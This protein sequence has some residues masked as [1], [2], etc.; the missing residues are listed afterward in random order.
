MCLCCEGQGHCLSAVCM[1]SCTG[2]GRGSGLLSAGSVCGSWVK[3]S[4]C[5]CWAR[6]Y[7]KH[8]SQRATR[9]RWDQPTAL[10]HAFHK[11]GMSWILNVEIC[12]CLQLHV[13]TSDKCC[14]NET[15]ICV[16]LINIFITAAS[17]CRK[18]G[19]SFFLS[20]CQTKLITEI[21]GKIMTKTEK[22]NPEN[23][24]GV[25]CELVNCEIWQH[26]VDSI[27]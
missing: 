1:Y 19:F 4:T 14:S 7:L 3:K 8:F 2:R 16:C 18:K 9:P 10:M 24:K 6:D 26:C 25:N 12:L 27:L 11:H 23:I 17:P 5:T 15:R 21:Y 20:C 13:Q 22:K